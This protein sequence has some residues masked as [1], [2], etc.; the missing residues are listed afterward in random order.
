MG[1]FF[2]EKNSHAIKN[3]PNGEISPNLV[4]LF[5]TLATSVAEHH[6]CN[7]VHIYTN[8][9]DTSFDTNFVNANPEMVLKKLLMKILFGESL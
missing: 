1:Q 7:E 4:T 6:E 2:L 9:G 3:H 5:I 8:F